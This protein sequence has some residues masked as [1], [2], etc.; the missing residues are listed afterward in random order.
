M[1]S[2]VIRQRW[3]WWATQS[4]AHPRPRGTSGIQEDGW[5]TRKMPVQATALILVATLVCFTLGALGHTQPWYISK[6]RE[7]AEKWGPPFGV[8][9]HPLVP[10]N[11]WGVPRQIKDASSCFAAQLWVYGG[12]RCLPL[13]W[14]HSSPEGRLP[15]HQRART[16]LRLLSWLLLS[17]NPSP[18]HELHSVTAVANAYSTLAMHQGS[19]LDLF[20]HLILTTTLGSRFYCHSHLTDGAIEARRGKMICPRPDSYVRYINYR[21]RLQ[22]SHHF[23]KIGLSVLCVWA[24]KN[25]LHIMNTN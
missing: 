21:T 12:F 16:H 4:L 17:Q 13:Y 3:D 24:I 22:N 11:N 7:H 10:N 14:W 1:L 8:E 15:H 23:L 19:S 9:I 6:I 18:K 5:P 2:C 20:I 25:S